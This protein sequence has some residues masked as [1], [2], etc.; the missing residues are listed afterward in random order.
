MTATETEIATEML[1]DKHA[2]G[3]VMGMAALTIADTLT[4]HYFDVRTPG[5]D[6]SHLLQ[7]TNARGLLCDILISVGGSVEWECRPIV[8]DQADPVRTAEMV[9][10]ILGGNAGGRPAE[11]PSSWF[12]FKSIVGRLLA[13]SGMDVS[14]QTYEDPL[15]FDVYSEISVTNPAQP[16]RGRARIADD[17]LVTWQCRIRTQPDDN[18]A[19]DPGEIAG[20]IAQALAGRDRA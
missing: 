18:R 7:V 11:A 14:V 19:I 15:F 6:G 8:S 20:I 13:D 5:W 16:G 3:D 1:A 17:G 4:G 9:R 2:A 12:G 10:R